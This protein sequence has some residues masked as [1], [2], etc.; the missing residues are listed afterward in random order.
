MSKK[1]CDSKLYISAAL[2]EHKCRNIQAARNYLN[3]GI[4]VHKNCK[5]LRLEQFGIEIQFLVNK[6]LESSHII[7]QKYKETIDHFYDDIELHITLLEKTLQVESIN[8]LQYNV[9]L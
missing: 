6:G 9:M 2:F 1:K 5:K 8:H 4:R 7:M 3:E